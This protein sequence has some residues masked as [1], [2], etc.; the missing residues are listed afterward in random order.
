MPKAHTRIEDRFAR[1]KLG[2]DVRNPI[3]ETFTLSA[4]A[5]RSPIQDFRVNSAVARTMG[6]QER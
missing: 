4:I 5:I 2:C 6:K 3:E 1:I